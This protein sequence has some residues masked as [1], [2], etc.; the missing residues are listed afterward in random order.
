M[1]GHICVVTTLHLNRSKAEVLPFIWDIKNIEYCEVKADDVQVNRETERT[2]TYTI[3][4]H[5]ARFIPWTRKFKY[6][7]H[8]RGFHSKEAGFPPSE[9]D[10][11]GG[12]F[13]EATS[14]QE[15]E[16]IHYEQYTLPLK[17]RLLQPFIVIYLK[18]S[19]LKE[20]AD[21]KRLISS[22]TGRVSTLPEAI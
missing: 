10:I 11:Q 17:F 15:C 20:M 1:S 14:E 16:I 19:Q 8:D 2:G 4:G 18:W 21:L 5:F 22:K 12:F 7:L 3:H 13:V 6:E 9:L